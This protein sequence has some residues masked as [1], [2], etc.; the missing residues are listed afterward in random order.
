MIKTPYTVYYIGTCISTCYAIEICHVLKYKAPPFFSFSCICSSITCTLACTSSTSFL[1]S[2]CCVL[3]KV[4]LLN[5][6]QT[7]FASSSSF[8]FLHSFLY[9]IKIEQRLHIYQNN[10]YSLC[11]QISANFPSEI[12]TILLKFR[13]NIYIVIN[14]MPVV[15]HLNF[16]YVPTLPILLIVNEFKW[17]LK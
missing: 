5:S 16:K 1:R 15:K 17:I 13:S 12:N 10:Y 2:S 8:S 3:N 4:S 7:D 14:T 6:A 9:I 11:T